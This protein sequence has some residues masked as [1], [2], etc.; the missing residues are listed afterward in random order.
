MFNKRLTKSY[1]EKLYNV[2]NRRDSVEDPI[3]I[4]KLFQEDENKEILAFIS[5]LYA[6]GNIKQINSALIK[7]F[8]ILQP[9]AKKR[10]LDRDY[11]F[12]LRKNEDINH[13]FLFHNEFLNI[14]LTLN[15]VLNEYKSIKNLF[16]SG[17]DPEEINLKSAISHFSKKLR[18]YYNHSVILFN[19]K[20]SNSKIFNKI[21]DQTENRKLKFLFPDPFSNSTCKRMNLFLRW[22]V[23]K[24][25]VDFGLWG[26]IKT[27]QLVIPLDSHIYQIAKFYNLTKKKS[28]SWNMAFEIT[29]QLKKF[30]PSDPIKYDFALSHL[31]L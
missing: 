18:E 20:K 7:I 30:D 21:K 16:L 14:L 8:R 25:N 31:K 12:Y 11:I 6:F 22:M 27:S 28:P 23:R 5:S 13:R 4:V 17:Y 19:Q 24:D 26:E 15:L 3:Q 29:E 1:L 10:I 2:Y 9:S